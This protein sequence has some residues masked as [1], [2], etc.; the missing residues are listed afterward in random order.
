MDKFSIICRR[1][2]RRENFTNY[3]KQNLW[4]LTTLDKIKQK[5][6]KKKIYEFKHER[7]NKVLHKVFLHTKSMQKKL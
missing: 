5:N 2:K 1:E 4:R 7:C 6:Q 3:E